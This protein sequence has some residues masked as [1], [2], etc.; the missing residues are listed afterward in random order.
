M[1]PTGGYV[2]TKV[3]KLKIK[4]LTHTTNTHFDGLSSPIDDFVLAAGHCVS[5]RWQHFA[6]N[7]AVYL[8]IKQEIDL[9]P[10]RPTVGK[11]STIVKQII[12][13]QN[14]RS[15]SVCY[16]IINAK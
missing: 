7:T 3:R 8:L 14:R 6:N 16:E 9:G 11:V 10:S 4:H 13:R 12:R 2:L 1:P 5:I 15:L